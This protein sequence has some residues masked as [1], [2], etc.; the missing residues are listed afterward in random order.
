MFAEGSPNVPGKAYARDSDIAGN[1]C[2]RECNIAGNARLQNEVQ[3]NLQI[4]QVYSC[5]SNTGTI[6]CSCHSNT[7]APTV[8]E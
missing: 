5:H 6:I 1:G 2:E 3:H 7:M 4:M 8:R